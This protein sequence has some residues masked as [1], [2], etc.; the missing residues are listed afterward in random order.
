MSLVHLKKISQTRYIDKVSHNQ[1]QGFSLNGNLRNSSYIGQ[2]S[3]SKKNRVPNSSRNGGVKGSGGNQNT[4]EL[5]L[6]CCKND[7]S[8]V[9]SSVKN[10]SGMLANKNRHVNR[11]YP[12]S[13]VK[14]DIN[15]NDNQTQSTYIEK[16]RNN[17]KCDTTK[18]LFEFQNSD[19]DR[20]NQL[21]KCLS[22]IP[23]PNKTNNSACFS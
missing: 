13:I 11:P 1:S 20:R 12:F 17:N 22:I 6:N 18:R 5:F 19:R 16:I 7:S 10:N 3:L 2:T 14:P 15:M 9:K 8:I 4:K 23:I 21:G